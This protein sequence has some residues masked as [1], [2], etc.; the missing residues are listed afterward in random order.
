MAIFTAI[1]LS[2]S[3]SGKAIPIVSTSSP[4]DTLHTV[5]SATTTVIEDVYI[6][7]K[8]A[9]TTD[10]T[11]ILENGG[12]ATTNQS[13]HLIPALSSVR[14]AAGDRY[15]SATGIVIRGFATAT[16]GL[17]ASGAVNRASP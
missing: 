16:G 6:D 17:V 7:I 13:R 15:Q 14:V 9:A 3:T 1:I 4:G 11:F 2:G 8:S 5:S 12:T 10:R